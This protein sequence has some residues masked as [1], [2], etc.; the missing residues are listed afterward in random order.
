MP[1]ADQASARTGTGDGKGERRGSCRAAIA[2]PPVLRGAGCAGAGGVGTPGAFPLPISRRVA[3]SRSGVRAA[4]LHH[5]TGRHAV[6]LCCPRRMHARDA[7]TRGCVCFLLLLSDGGIRLPSDAC[8]CG[9]V[10]PARAVITDLTRR[11]VHMHLCWGGRR[12]TSLG[13]PL[14]PHPHWSASAR[15]CTA[16]DRRTRGGAGDRYGRACAAHVECARAAR[17]ELSDGTSQ[18]CLAGSGGACA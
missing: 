6:P 8:A 2:T 12:R 1:P 9:C 7:W 13:S 11:V 16:T 18:A 5:R 10:P 15:L 17:R 3:Q 4:G 14:S